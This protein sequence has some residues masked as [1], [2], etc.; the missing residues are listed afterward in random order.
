MAYI[1]TF[2]VST[3]GSASMV[4]GAAR[5]FGSS[6]RTVIFEDAT[7]PLM[8]HTWPH[9]V[10]TAGSTSHNPGVVTSCVVGDI[11]GLSAHSIAVGASNAASNSPPATGSDT[12][13]VGAVSVIVTL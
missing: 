11:C 1:V 10:G 8:A 2:A 3:S 5:V 4:A 12:S 13:A 9:P 6:S 7:G